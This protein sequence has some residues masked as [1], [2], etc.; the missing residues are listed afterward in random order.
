MGAKIERYANNAQSLLNG[1]IDNVTTTVVVD[2]ASSFPTDGQFRVIVGSEVMIVTGVSSN[3]FTVLRGQDGSAAASHLDDTP[4]VH[5]FTYQSI[6]KILR[7]C[8]AAN[9]GDIRPLVAGT[10]DEEFDGTADT[11]P[12]DW[13]WTSAPSGSDAFTLNSN[14]PS[15]LTLEGT[16]NASYTLTRSSFAPGT[17]AFGIW[18]KVWNG[19]KASADN[20]NVT[21]Y[22]RNAGDTEGKA[23]Q[24]RSTNVE[25][26]SIRGL[27]IKSSSETAAFGGA[28]RTLAKGMNCFY[29]G[30]TRTAGDVWRGWYSGD[31][32]AWDLLG[33]TDT[34]SFTVAKIMFLMGT[35]AQQSFQAIDW[36]RYRADNLFPRP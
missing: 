15:V 4:I 3:T 8:G 31:G 27:Q 14:W 28:S 30:L 6:I 16:G 9:Y 7:E 20:A 21:M 18:A 5:I 2:S 12:T 19:Y 11:L 13:A 25:E 34:H 29:Y 23:I 1:G 33:S 24:V 22:I 10:Y 17:G 36:V 26:H 32:V 35:E